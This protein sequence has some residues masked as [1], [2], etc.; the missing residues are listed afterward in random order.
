MSKAGFIFIV[1]YAILTENLSAQA[2]WKLWASGLPAGVFPKLT[3]AP[4]HDIYYGLTGTTGPKGVL[5]RGNTQD[6]MGIFSQLPAIPLP[7]SVTNNIQILICNQNND[8]IAGIFRSNAA[9]PFLFLFDHNTQTWQSVVVDFLPSLGAFCA[10]RSD[11][12]HLWI[13]SKWSYIYKS[14]DHGKSFARIDES[15]LVKLN[16]PCYYPSWSGNPSDGAIYSINVDGTGKIYAGTEGAGIIYSED[17]GTTWHPADLNA[18]KLNAAFEKDSASPLK[19]LSYTGNLGAIGFTKDNELIFNGTNMWAIGWKQELGFADLKNKFAIQSQ[20]FPDYFISS[21][22]QVTQIVSTQNG[23]LF[24][25]SGS[26]ASVAGTVGIYSSLDGIHWNLLNTGI[27]GNGNTGQA[28]GSLAVDGNQVFMATTDGRIWNLDASTLTKT[29]QSNRT[30]FNLFPN[31]VAESI[32]ILT[33]AFHIGTQFQIFNSYG[34]LVHIGEISSL[35]TSIFVNELV[36]GI[37]FI[38]MNGVQRRFIKI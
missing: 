4:N 17:D 33:D 27:S 7:N 1:I 35:K 2:S 30:N 19:A 14:T 9:D 28:Q 20:G 10:A 25:H 3:V 36:P 11:D 16:Y 24:L 5:Y 34:I 38:K 29:N 8:L 6:P 22:L 37:Y 26:N 31:P 13:G 21:G 18:C 15:A 23:V 32:F 12:G